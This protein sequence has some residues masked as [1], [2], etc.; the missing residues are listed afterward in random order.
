[1]PSMTS[2][3]T[4]SAVIPVFNG[5][6]YLPEAIRSAL[7]QS[8]RPVE[9]IVVDDGSTDATP[10]TIEQFGRDVTYVRQE[11]AGVSVARNRGAALAG[12]ELVAFLDHDD[13]WL[14]NKLERQVELLASSPACMALCAMSIVDA[15]GHVRATKHLRA[16]EDLLTGMLLFDGTE[17]VSCSSTGVI[18]RAALLACGGFDPAL[19]TSADWDLLVRML[20]A[21]PVAYVDEPL[22]LYRLHDANM[23]RSV[24][25]ME[26]DM[27][28]A[29]DKAFAD[30]RLPADLYRR[31]RR[32]YARLYR[33]LA[34][35]YRDSGDTPAA[36]RTLG[37][38]LLRD[39]T[40]PAE[41]VRHFAGRRREGGHRSATD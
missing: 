18:E 26:R 6:R 35:S 1:M 30:R 41:L 32:A 10:Q 28:H 7:G 39:P 12:G 9:C 25:A 20:L 27:R 33:M 31:R 29:F 5:A 4:V 40:I 14:P 11:R 17:T 21:G 2:L 22:V 24:R 16:R 23:S 19:S 34:G 37:M 38:A 8:H 13:A 3:V 36:L 15:Q